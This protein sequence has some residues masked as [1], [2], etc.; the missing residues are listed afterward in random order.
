[1]FSSTGDIEVTVENVQELM[2]AA[3]MMEIHHVVHVAANFL[4][5]ELSPTNAIGIYRYVYFVLL[6]STR[7]L[8]MSW[9]FEETRREFS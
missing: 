1:M 4:K 6:D 5:K 8:V 9:N 2:V 7:T 3:D